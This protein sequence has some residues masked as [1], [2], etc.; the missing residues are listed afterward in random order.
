MAVLGLKP[1]TCRAIVLMSN[2]AAD[3][4]KIF[5]LYICGGPLTAAVIMAGSSGLSPIYHSA[6]LGSAPQAFYQEI[7]SYAVLKGLW[8]GIDI[9]AL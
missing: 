1:A 2:N 9:S 8:D 5:L 4:A 6:K 3:K 7:I